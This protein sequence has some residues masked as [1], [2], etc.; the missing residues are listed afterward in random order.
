MADLSP[1]KLRVRISDYVKTGREN[2]AKL[3][4][5]MAEYYMKTQDIEFLTQATGRSRR[6]VYNYLTIGY[7]LLNGMIKPRQ[8]VSLGTMK[9]LAT[10]HVWM[11]GELSWKLET[12]VD[13]RNVVSV[14]KGERLFPVMFYLNETAREELYGVLALLGGV[15]QGRAMRSKEKALLK[16]VKVYQ[17]FEAEN[18]GAQIAS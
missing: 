16:L 11:H 3:F 9:L 5:A 13:S 15:R 7:G 4:R 14:E 12:E 8:V 17:E 10:R 1:D 6:M 2:D 18:E